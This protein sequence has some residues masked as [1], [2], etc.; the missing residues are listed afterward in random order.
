[1]LR[2][3]W[4]QANF[5][6]VVDV[7]GKP[8]QRRLQTLRDMIEGSG[9]DGR[10]F[11]IRIVPDGD[12]GFVHGKGGVITFEDGNKTAFIGSANDSARAWTKNYELVWEDS[13]EESVKWMEEE[14]EALWEKAFSL[15]DYIVKQIGRLGERTIIERVEDWRSD[16]KVDVALAEAPTVT[17]LFGFWDHQKY[18]IDLAFK[19]HL[20][21]KDDPLRGARFLLADGVGLGKTLQLGATAKLIGAFDPKRPILIMAPKNLL[22]QWQGELWEKLGMPSAYWKGDG[23]LTERDE[24]HPLL[25]DNTLN[26][27]RKVGLVSTSIV[28]SATIS[29][30]NRRLK[31]DLLRVRFSCVIWDEAHKIRRG[32]LTAGNV[33]N[34]PDKNSWYEWAERLAG[35]TKTMLLATA[36]PIQLHPMELWDL[37]NVLSV[38]NDQVLGGQ[39]SRWRDASGPH[40]FDLVAGRADVRGE[41][42]KW[43]YWRDPLPVEPVEPFGWIR[44]TLNVAETGD[45]AD[46][47]DFDRLA[48][49]ESDYFSDLD[50]REVNPFV[51]RVVKRTRERLE[52]EGKLV[53]IDM[54]PLEEQGRPI[55]C[56]HSMSE[57]FE[58]AE[59]FAKKLHSR[60][61]AS[62]FIKTLLQRRIGSSL[63]AGLSTTRRM[64]V[65]RELEDDE[66]Q[67]DDKESLYP[68]EAEEIEVLQQLERHL[69]RQLTTEGDP[70]MTRVEELLLRDFEGKTLLELGVL[71]F[72]QFYDSAYALAKHLVDKVDVPIGLY[73]GSGA[74]RFFDSGEERSVKQEILKEMVTA[75][76]LKILIGTDA[77]STGLNLQRLGALINLDLPWNPTILEQ[78]K[79]RVQRGTLSKR[80]PFQDLWYDEGVEA[81][82]RQTL[83]VRIKEITDVFGCVP[84]F[85]VDRWVKD[86]LDGK[87]DEDSFVT[88][89]SE[90]KEN[91]FEV[92]QRDEH[93][94]EDWDSCKEVLNDQGLLRDFKDSW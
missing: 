80:I 63:Q 20:R 8:A 89:L 81:R 73:A 46:R 76:R 14:F 62:G 84:D 92:K 40:V 1:M 48:A 91:P 75:G 17:Q 93:L 55:T 6:R 10:T 26:C 9:K 28:T 50:L 18:F 23:W 94:T 72:S 49:E 45:Y 82:L 13:A 66:N 30:R 83:S 38:N 67:E 31:E 43:D 77:A 21:Y 7:Q 69:D 54:V 2:L 78:R 16:P 79:G 41:F 24:F 22:P 47:A 64:L 61:K 44:Q 58:L 85:F 60:V 90:A 32:N 59:I 35:Q 33:F 3:V 42:D 36:T 19:E 88:I 71:I 27:P 25:P 15:S 56:T 39:Y 51:S 57:A 86:M 68:L 12:F 4:N 37:L 34:P 70:K 29:E 52:E 65:G 5:A 11:E 53:P 87:P 74:S